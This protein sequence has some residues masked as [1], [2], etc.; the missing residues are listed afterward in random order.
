MIDLQNDIAI[1]RELAKEYAQIALK[2]S[3][4]KLDLEWAKLNDMERVAPKIFVTPDFDGVGKE[5]IQEII[6]KTKELLLKELK[7]IQC[8]F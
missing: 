6:N 5:I 3:E 4:E 1:L 8:L 2:S 7:N